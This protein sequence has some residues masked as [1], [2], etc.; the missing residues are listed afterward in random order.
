MEDV[1]AIARA[2]VNDMGDNAFDE[3]IEDA[4]KEIMQPETTPSE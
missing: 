2:L 3:E 4:L 1:Y